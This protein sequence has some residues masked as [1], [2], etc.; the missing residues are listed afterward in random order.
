MKIFG[1]KIVNGWKA[2]SKDRDRMECKVRMGKLTFLEGY[3]DWS[4]K[5]LKLCVLNFSWAK[6]FK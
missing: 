4:D 5:E 2:P 3:Y 6:K 1:Q